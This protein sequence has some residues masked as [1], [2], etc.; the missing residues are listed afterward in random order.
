MKLWP[1]DGKNVMVKFDFFSADRCYAYSL[2]GNYICE[3]RTPELLPYF[4][5]DPAKLAEHIERTRED[6]KI[7]DALIRQETGGWGM[8]D[9]ATAL[10]QPR[11]AFLGKAP[12]RLQDS[13]YMVKANK[14]NPK[15]YLLK[16]EKERLDAE[17]AQTGSNTE[18]VSHVTIPEK[19]EVCS[20]EQKSDPAKIRRL[21]E[22]IRRKAEDDF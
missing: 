8:V 15:Y 5:A 4:N 12:L 6:K 1:F 21:A 11:E 14:H 18:T 9:M 16:D 17:H 22:L 3:L 10:R 2:D 7:F 19:K 20:T 13:R